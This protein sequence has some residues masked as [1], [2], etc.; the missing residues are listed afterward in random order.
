M[1][2]CPACLSQ[3]WSASEVTRGGSHEM[4][5]LPLAL[6]GQKA[7]GQRVQNHGRDGAAMP[8]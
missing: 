2:G 7:V 1:Q 8:F 5:S 3:L 4:L 6:L